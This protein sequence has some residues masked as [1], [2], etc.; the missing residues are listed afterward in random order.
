MSDDRGR[1]MLNMMN[2]AKQRKREFEQ[3]LLQDIADAEARYKRGLKQGW[4]EAGP[5]RSGIGLEEIRAD[6]RAAAAETPATADQ[7]PRREQRQ[8]L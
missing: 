6:R 7:D 8:Q 5:G 3:E 2:R 1:E 4:D